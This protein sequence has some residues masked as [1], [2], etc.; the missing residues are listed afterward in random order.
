MRPKCLSPGSGSHRPGRPAGRRPA[1]C[2]CPLHQSR[3]PSVH[4]LGRGLWLW[5]WSSLFRALPWEVRGL[6]PPPQRPPLFP[7]PSVLPPKLSWRSAWHRTPV[8]S[9]PPWVLT[10][11][12]GTPV[13]APQCPT[14]MHL[15]P[16]VTGRRT[17]PALG[18]APPFPASQARLPPVPCRPV[19]LRS[20]RCP[21]TVDLPPTHQFPSPAR[22]D[23]ALSV[24]PPWDAP[25]NPMGV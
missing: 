7:F 2:T 13:P 8:F 12:R 4:L 19:D 25:S 21:A 22:R 15:G 11:P 1:R 10:L 20:P 18:T 24:T 9:P 3:D 17:S 6:T 23:T 16:Q 14:L 5:P